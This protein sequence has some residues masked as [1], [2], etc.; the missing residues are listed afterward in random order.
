MAVGIASASLMVHAAHYNSPSARLGRLNTIIAQV[1]DILIRARVKG[2]L[3]DFTLA[4]SETRLL[5]YVSISCLDQKLTEF[6]CPE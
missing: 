1:D 6:Y 2:M 3:H 4:G 5:Q